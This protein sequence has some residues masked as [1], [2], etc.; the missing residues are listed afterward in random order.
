MLEQLDQINWRQLS[1]AYGPATD[2]PEMIRGLATITPE[3]R[4]QVLA[5]VWSSI[6]HQG[7]LYT[8]TAAAIPF[9]IELLNEP[10]VS[11]KNH[12]LDLLA[13]TAESALDAIQYFECGDGQRDEGIK[14]PIPSFIPPILTAVEGEWRLYCRLLADRDAS[15][16]ISAALLL[17]L[18][19]NHR[20]EV[21]AALTQAIDT[22]QNDRSRAVSV[23][24]LGLLIER[25]RRDDAISQSTIA[26]IKEVFDEPDSTCA[27]LAAAIA[28]VRLEIEEAIPG[29]LERDWPALVTEHEFFVRIPWEHDWPFA[30]IAHSLKSAPEA[31]LNWIFKGLA[32]PD[33]KVQ[34]AAL[35]A[36]GDYCRDF[37]A[38]PSR[39]APEA[40]RLVDSPDES[41]R[42]AAVRSLK[43]MGD[44]GRE[45]LRPHLRGLKSD[46]RREAQ[47]AFKQVDFYRRTKA[48]PG[49][50][51]NFPNWVSTIIKAIRRSLE[52]DS[53]PT[54]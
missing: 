13:G 28:L 35:Y 12:V 25:D 15:V 23:L 36:A 50:S 49:T 37:D 33:P 16:R 9:L 42:R 10:S 1:H 14:R 7:S 47:A 20:A 30:I 17:R 2:V 22:D 52:S 11:E 8:A 44:L 27:A 19:V 18:M 29:L 51:A 46:V 43:Y 53:R 26:K 24:A 45:C 6:L 40:V 41:V 39:L 31:Q 3:N 21:A 5:E 34:T 4:E 32:Y 54:D 38:G 48:R